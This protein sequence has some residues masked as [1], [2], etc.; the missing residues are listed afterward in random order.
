MFSGMLYL[1]SLPVS[2][3][4]LYTRSPSAYAAYR[5]FCMSARVEPLTTF[6]KSQWESFASRSSVCERVV[7]PFPL[8]DTPTSRYVNEDSVSASTWAFD[9]ASGSLTPSAVTPGASCSGR[10]VVVGWVVGSVV[11]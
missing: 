1:A 2:L 11:A 7:D 5:P 4:T 3:R 8:S 6:V 10:S 9:S